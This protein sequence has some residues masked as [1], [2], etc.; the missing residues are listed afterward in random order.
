MICRDEAEV[1][2]RLCILGDKFRDLFCQRKYAEALFTY[3]TAST[4]AVFMDAD[5]DLLNFLFGHGNTEETD[6]KVLFNREWVS[7]AHLECLKRGQNAP[8][9]YLEKEDMVRILES[10]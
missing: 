8:Y 9:I 1:V 5:Y 6:E 2:D 3:H 4:V 10:L 7:R